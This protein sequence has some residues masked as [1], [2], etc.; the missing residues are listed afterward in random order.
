M[1]RDTRYIL[2]VDGGQT[3]TACVLGTADGEI[4]AVGHGG[5]ANHFHQPGGSERLSRAIKQSVGAARADAGNPSHFAAVYLALTGGVQ[6]G[7]EIARALFDADVL[8]AEGDPPAALASG[9]FGGPGIG[10]IAG[11]GAVA[12]AENVRGERTLRGGWGYLVGDEGS[13]Y[14]IGMRAVQAAARALD[15]RGPSTELA[16][17]VPEFYGE[18]SL[19]NVASRIYGFELER[20]E[21]AALAPVV[22]DAAA[23]GDSV[24]AHIVDLAAEELALLLE[25]VAQAAAFTEQQERVIVAAGGVL[26]PGNLLWQRLAT[27]VDRRLPHFRLIAPRFP[28]VI[29]AYVLALRLAGVAVDQGVIDRIDQSTERFPQLAGKPPVGV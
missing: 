6:Q 2:A 26:R 27:Q 3:N 4:L 9:T 17:R 16:Q 15:G 21:L 13:G 8:L 7:E 23:Q 12:L 10:L 29:G 24:A 22:L 11:T 1:Q 28:P 14:W 20:P 18:T 25:A 5:P 19:R